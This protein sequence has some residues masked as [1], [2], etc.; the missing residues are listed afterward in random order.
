MVYDI[1]SDPDGMEDKAAAK[2]DAR[3]LL[4]I[5][6]KWAIYATVAFFLSCV[7]LVPFL[8]GFPLHAYW[9]SLGKFFLLLS[10][11]L[12]LPFVAFIGRA[13]NAWLFVRDMEKIDE[14]T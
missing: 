1:D 8:A 5:R 7:S 10:M 14:C 2:E 9:E 12:L 6:S 13:I 4:R 3:H 11:T